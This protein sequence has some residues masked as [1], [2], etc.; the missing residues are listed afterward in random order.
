MYTACA[1]TMHSMCAMNQY[2]RTWAINFFETLKCC[3][4][5]WKLNHLVRITTTVCLFDCFFLF[6]NF[7]QKKNTKMLARVRM[8]DQIEISR[9]KEEKNC[10][11]QM[12][13]IGLNEKMKRQHR[14]LL[15]TV[16]CMCFF[17][18]SLF[19]N[20]FLFLSWK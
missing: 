7:R 3:S 11:L 13:V 19:H 10:D 14:N 20:H 1:Y 5:N 4:L 12:C 9:K 17:F 18:S 2:V 8:T 15:Y 6:W 16:A